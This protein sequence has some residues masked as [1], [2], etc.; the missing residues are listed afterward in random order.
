MPDHV[1]L[2]SRRYFLLPHTGPVFES[3]DASCFRCLSCLALHT[4]EMSL[5]AGR[6]DM[7]N[8]NQIACRRSRYAASSKPL[9][10]NRPLQNVAMARPPS[11]IDAPAGLQQHPSH[12]QLRPARSRRI[13]PKFDRV[14]TASTLLAFA[15]LALIVTPAAA[16]HVPLTNCLSES[17]QHDEPFGLQWVPIWADASYATE[18]SKRTLQYVVWGDVKGSQSG[19][20]LP[21]PD[22]P[23]NYWS[24]IEQTDGKI[25]RSDSDG[26]LATTLFR[27]V[28]VLTYQPVNDPVDFC[29]DA[30]TNGSCP[31]PP[32]FNQTPM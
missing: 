25:A 11:T 2:L 10:S 29:R 7:R 1:S 9:A 31:L 18:G 23:S 14:L 3:C 24:D 5:Q 32:L 4:A 15:L 27:R 26:K 19:K 17:T 22:D 28:E 21:P 8:S 20:R 13:L 30:L 16:V 12:T 6:P